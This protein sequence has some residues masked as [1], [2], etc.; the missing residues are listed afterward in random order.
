M[1]TVKTRQEELAELAK[2]VGTAAAAKIDKMKGEI[3][4]AINAKNNDLVAGLIS[5]KDFDLFKTETVAQLQKSLDILSDAVKTQGTSINAMNERGSSGGSSF[6]SLGQIITDNWDAIKEAWTNRRGEVVID[7]K[8]AGLNTLTS[9]LSPM[10][11]PPNNPYAPNLDG[12]AL[13][14]FDILRNPAFITAH[15]SVGTT[16]QPRLAWINELTNTGLG[17]PAIVS[18]GGLKPQTQHQFKVEISNA[19]KIAAYISMTEEFQ[20]DIPYLASQIQRL[21]TRDVLR[22][23]DDQVQTDVIANS[24]GFTTPNPLS[25]AIA[26][27]TLWDA[28]GAGLAQI[29]AL[30]YVPNTIGLNPYTYWKLLMIKDS[31]GKYNVPPFLDKIDSMISQANKVFPNMVIL[32][33]LKQFNVDIY[34]DLSI[35]I[36]W[37]NDD[38]VRNQ[39]TIVAEMRFHDYIS[40]ARKSAIAYYNIAAA[41]VNINGTGS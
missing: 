35:R 14:L 18:E 27:A 41:R 31:T 33:D 40:T 7:L 21:L 16:N 1:E 2:E 34:K 28:I 3:T 30:N 22:A 6:K 23:F 25:G 8:A 17:S 32:G 13:Q 19:K 20:D 26:S 10:D 29:T 4:D 11:S 39:F 37:Q 9:T 12:S 36:G 15:T 5:Q 24:T 38:F